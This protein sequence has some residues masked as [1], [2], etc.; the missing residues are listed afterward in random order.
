[1]NE[2]LVPSTAAEPPAH[3]ASILAPAVGV[4]GDVDLDPASTAALPGGH[5]LWQRD[6]IAV[7]ARVRA[8]LATLQPVAVRVLA[9]WDHVVRTV[10]VGGRTVEVDPSGCYRVR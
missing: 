6:A 7:S 10:R 3:P 2:A 4:A 9:F 5:P 8:I 1:M